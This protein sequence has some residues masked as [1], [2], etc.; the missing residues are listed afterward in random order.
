MQTYREALVVLFFFLSVIAI[1]LPLYLRPT[2]GP[3]APVG[4]SC[5]TCPEDYGTT[6]QFLQTNGVNTLNWT[7]IIAYAAGRISSVAPIPFGVG[8]TVP[9]ISSSGTNYVSKNITDTGTGWTVIEPGNYIISVGINIISIV[10]NGFGPGETIGGSSQLFVNGVL[11]GIFA[12]MQGNSVVAAINTDSYA[13]DIFGELPVTLAAGDLIEL[14][15]SSELSGAGPTQ[16]LRSGSYRIE[17][18]G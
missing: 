16:F 11:N 7:T 1:L 6:G 17:F 5:A 9:I 18:L 2:C 3:A 15:A 12:F 14:R 13:Q 4:N 8:V 10:P